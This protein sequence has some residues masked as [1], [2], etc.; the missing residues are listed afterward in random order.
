MFISRKKAIKK[1]ETL[2]SRISELETIVNNHK[3]TIHDLIVDSKISSWE[4]CY[5]EENGWFSMSY[6]QNYKIGDVVRKI[7]DHLNLKIEK[8]NECIGL[9]KKTKK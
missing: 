7:L 2:E 4:P 8:Y 3:V 9:V 6:Q 1:F 5:K